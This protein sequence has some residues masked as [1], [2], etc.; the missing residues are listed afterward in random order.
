MF[1][2]GRQPESEE[3]SQYRLTAMKITFKT[4]GHHNHLIYT[5]ILLGCQDI[6]K[7]VLVTVRGL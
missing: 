2:V 5:P 4:E 6:F 7:G 3:L 1:P